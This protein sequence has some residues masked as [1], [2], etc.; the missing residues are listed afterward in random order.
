MLALASC[1]GSSDSGPGLS[2]LPVTTA[3]RGVG[4]KSNFGTVVGNRYDCP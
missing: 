3:I 2:Q 4:L 1:G